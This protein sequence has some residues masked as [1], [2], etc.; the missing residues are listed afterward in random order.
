MY[1]KYMDIKNTHTKQN[2]VTNLKWKQKM[3]YIVFNFFYILQ[4][5]LYFY[6]FNLMYKIIFN[7]TKE[8][9]LI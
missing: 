1:K 6:I 7:K 8:N 9:G 4:Y 2:T 3:F 5:L